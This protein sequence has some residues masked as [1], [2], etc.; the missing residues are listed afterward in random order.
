MTHTIL[1]LQPFSSS[2]NSFIIQV[3]QLVF[4][5]PFLSGCGA[6]IQGRRMAQKG[7]CKTLLKLQVASEEIGKTVVLAQSQLASNTTWSSS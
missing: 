4:Q 2:A 5:E 1:F 7:P 3:D 6:W